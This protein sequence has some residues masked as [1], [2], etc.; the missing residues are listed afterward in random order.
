MKRYYL[1]FS[2]I[3]LCRLQ[4]SA[5]YSIQ[6][7]KPG[8]I[9]LKTADLWNCIVQNNSNGGLEVYLKGTITEKSRGKL[10]EVRSGA[11]QL[12]RGITIY[13]TAN[14]GDLKGETA[15]FSDK[16]FEDHVIRTN[17][18]PNGQYTFCAT[19]VDGK[20]NQSLANDCINFTI[21][22]VTA[23]LLIMPQNQSVI[24]ENYPVFVWER[25]RGAVTGS[26]LT[27]SI[28]I[29]E[30]LKSQNP[31]AAM[32]S[33]PC[34][35]CESFVNE[36]IHQFSFKAI[37]FQEDKRY[38]WSVTVVE[39]KKEIVRSDIWE[40]TWKNCGQGGVTDEEE[41][42]EEEEEE[43]ISN[44]PMPGVSY[45]YPSKTHSSELIAV[46][47]TSLNIRI[48]NHELKQDMEAMILNNTQKPLITK[49]LALNHGHNYYI[50]NIR[51]LKLEPMTPYSL[52][53]VTSNGVW[54]H[55][56]F[57][58]LNQVKQ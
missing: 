47:D 12:K 11:F 55:L 36:P 45:Y 51:S 57:F 37:P 10:Y 26:N 52:K 25:F 22:E 42:E 46:S 56:S 20:S 16:T 13:N 33:N 53:L 6:L 9:A 4:L 29:V 54:Y 48:I 21:N 34:F 24:C 58:T 30:I 8:I 18:L 28:R 31:N 39:G 14:Y 50:I 32:K 43:V 3:L 7:Q 17:T 19:I 1:F 23:P 41:E 35:Y 38:A 5:Q 27:Y 2:I 49:M 15:L 40:F 44:P